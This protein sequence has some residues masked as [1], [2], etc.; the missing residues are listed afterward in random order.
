MARSK[1]TL[2]GAIIVRVGDI[3]RHLKWCLN[4]TKRWLAH[5]GIL[6]K[7]PGRY[8]RTYTTFPELCLVNP[9][10]AHEI[11]ARKYCDESS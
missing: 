1:R 3:A 6:H 4:S 9:H 11:R 8:G 7:Q 10:I 5:E 2:E